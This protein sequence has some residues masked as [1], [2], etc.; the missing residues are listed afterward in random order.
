MEGEG[1]PRLGDGAG[2]MDDEAG[3]GRR[4][5]V[6]QAPAHRAIEVADRNRA[7]DDDRA[8]ALLAHAEHGLVVLVANVADDLLD[9]VLERHQSLHDA[10][11]VDD[12][13]RM[14]AAAQERLQLVAQRR[15]FRD[16]P[17]LR[18]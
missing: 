5:L 8:V 17:W 13:R 11:F 2:L 1:L 16:E 9:D 4:L 7:F 15:R 18:P 10:V 6:G 3:H 14:R 12:Q